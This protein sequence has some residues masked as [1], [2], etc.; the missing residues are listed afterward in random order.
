MRRNDRGGPTM[1]LQHGN[2]LASLLKN[3]PDRIR[4]LPAEA[5][6]E[7]LRW[8]YVI[9]SLSPCSVSGVLGAVF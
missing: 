8:I 4:L 5:Q 1:I 6:P 3:V 7:F 2:W 9:L